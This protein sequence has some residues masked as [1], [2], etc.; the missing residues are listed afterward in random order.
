MIEYVQVDGQRANIA[1]GK[2]Q[3]PEYF[4][5][6]SM[7]VLLGQNGSGKTRLMINVAEVLTSG[8]RIGDQGHWR[9]WDSN[10]LLTAR[11]AKD[12]PKGLGVL[13][14]TPLPY[15]RR[16]TPHERCIDASS[17]RSVATRSR[18]LRQFQF[19][20]HRLGVPT[21]L[22]GRLAYRKDIF[23]RLVVPRMLEAD[24]R[25]I[26]PL[27]E[28]R[29]QELG[30]Q[31]EYKFNGT[32]YKD[33][34]DHFAKGVEA[35]ILS[36]LGPNENNVLVTL[37]CLDHAAQ[38]P[39]QRAVFTQAFMQIVG[40][41]EFHESKADSRRSSKHD[42][43]QRFKNL[44]STTFD[45]L[46]V[47]RSWRLQSVNLQDQVGLEVQINFADSQRRSFSQIGAFDIEWTN[48]SS[49]L[50]SLVE[51]FTQ[52]ERGL[53]RLRRRGLLKVLILIDEGDAYL[54]MDWQRQYI[55]HLDQF[56]G[57][58]KKSLGFNSLQVLLATHSPIITGDFPAAMVQRLGPT[59]DN[60]I[61]PFGSSLDALVLETF[62]TPSIG[63][64]AANKIKGLREKFISDTLGPDDHALI[65]EIGDIGLRRAIK[66][67]AEDMQ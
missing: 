33:E 50:L 49:G 36:L 65:D 5:V 2:E 43:V 22:V 13:Y 42:A 35:W 10:G 63:E 23:R 37:A 41:A 60:N 28:S 34:V 55:L 45:F 1:P 4:S 26:D 8:T 9:G 11:D 46:D 66:S 3:F 67:R 47:A 39:S 24:C 20:A 51:Q 21:Q 40:I 59:L 17:F 27:M 64:F 54:H 44:L 32:S 56:L 53:E 38:S 14:Y 25:L 58:A 61:K 62:G 48:L 16:I 29:R 12:P 7:G 19:I 18:S 31:R 57:G 6:D 52:L 30:R 15:R